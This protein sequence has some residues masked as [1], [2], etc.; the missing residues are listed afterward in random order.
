MLGRMRVFYRVYPRLN[1][2]GSSPFAAESGAF[3][4]PTEPTEIPS[5]AVTESNTALP[6]PLDGRTLLRLSWSH[7]IELIRLEE[8]WK[9]AF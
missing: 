2:N 5:P 8:P 1:E 9:R 3:P 6:T 7:L 4:A